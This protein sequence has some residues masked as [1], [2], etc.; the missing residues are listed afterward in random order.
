MKILWVFAHPEQCS[1]NGSLMAEGLRTLTG[2]GHEHRVSDLYAMGW[3]P[4]VDGE[5]FGDGAHE[6]LFVG[7]EQERAYRE[8]QLS[9]D[10]R[11]EQEK[12][13]WADTLVFQF[14]LWWFGPPAIL[15]GWFDRVLV[16][17]FG[18]GVEGPDGRTLRYGDG[19]LAG[20]RALIVTS[21]GARESGFGPRGIHGSMEEVLFPL[22]HGT[23]WYTGMAAL[24]PFVVYGADR[25][26]E[27]GFSRTTAALR[28]RLRTLDT[29]EPLPF[30]HENGGEYDEHL[31]L[32]PDIAPDLTGVAAHRARDG[33]IP[34]GPREHERAGA[35]AGSRTR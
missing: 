24:P 30:R 14:P 28:E 15:K 18:F 6:R 9:R 17:G 5:D 23:F 22:L 12:I 7:R 16:Q 4:V 27:A 11:A 31:V 19:G 21:V 10:I 25:L 34:P 8:R 13:A 35:L 29:T 3:K 33:E 2:L 26:T 1:L 20:K 32:R